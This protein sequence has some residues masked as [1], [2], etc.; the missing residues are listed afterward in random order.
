MPSK[1]K[2]HS[3]PS[4]SSR[5]NPVASPI[6]TPKKKIQIQAIDVF[7]SCP[8]TFKL[9]A[10]S[11]KRMSLHICQLLGLEHLGLS[12]RFVGLSEISRLNQHFRQMAKPT[13]VLSFP[14]L[15]WKSRPTLAKPFSS[16]SSTKAKLSPLPF[17]SLLGEIVICP[18]KALKNAKSI[19]HD[20]DREVCFL[21]IHGI[22]HL[23]GHDHMESH[24]EKIMLE[25]QK[26]ILSKLE[27]NLDKPMW[28]HCI[29]SLGSK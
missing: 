12:I 3:I 8:R 28:K 14:L 26:Q 10:S 24:E 2:G 21:L 23:C 19:G 15:E 25:Q 7:S 27:K 17:D 11:I 1:S 5:R 29:K 18:H 4:R 22:L 6:K 13:D 20:L 9:N 16:P